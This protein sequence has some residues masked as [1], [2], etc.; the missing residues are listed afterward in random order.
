M[1]MAVLR[2]GLAC[3]GVFAAVATA[4]GCSST[5]PEDGGAGGSSG[6]APTASGSGGA[7]AGSGGSGLTAGGGSGAGVSNGASG[8][9]GA[10]ASSGGAGGAGAG[11]SAGGGTG[12]SGSGGAASGT[13]PSAGCNKPPTQELEKFVEGKVT[14]GQFERTYYVRLPA[15]YNPARA[16]TTVVVAAPCGGDGTNG[17]PIYEASKD[18]AIVIGLK[19]DARVSGR[20]CFQT[21]SAD[22]PEIGYFDAALAA[23][24]AGFCVDQNRLFMEGFSSGSWLTNLIGCARGDLLRGQGNASGGPPPLP[25]CKGPIATIM[26]HD[27]NDPANQYSGGL[28]TRD[29]IKKL[30]GCSDMTKDWDPAFPGCVEFQGCMPGFPLVFCTTMGKGH[31]ENKP[32]STEGFWKF[33]SALGPKP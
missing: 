24:E 32:Y 18:A 11:G 23:T 25:M 3:V 8:G 9:A 30:N 1:L 31:T 4:M 28:T 22:S 33:W 12:G 10:T 6:S 16:Y 7:S 17:I 13:K 21:E 14:V 15:N 19:P 20:D 27:T 5:T 26:V 29:R 2:P